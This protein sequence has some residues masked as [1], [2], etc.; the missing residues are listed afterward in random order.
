MAF[1]PPAVAYKLRGLMIISVLA[2]L[3][4]RAVRSRS[5][6]ISALVG[7][8]VVGGGAQANGSGGSSQP[9]ATVAEV[10]VAD[11]GQAEQFRAL[12]QS[13]KKMDTTE[14]T[15]IAIPST[16]PVDALQFTSNFGVRSD[17]FRGT[18]A[19]HSGVDIP[20]PIGTPIYA[21]ADGIV[22]RAERAGGYGNLIEVNHGR[23]IETR[24]GHL[25]K[26]LVEP[27]TR[28]RRGQLIGLMGST[29]RSTGSHLHY[30][31]RVEGH[32]VNPVPYLQVADMGVAI[33][34]RALKVRQVAV[35]GPVDER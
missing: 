18:A 8:A 35:G 10:G 16:Q 20:G 22:A 5:F 31:V 7:A 15:A 29:G 24:Y 21:T 12:F 23:G 26:I 9:V 17:P 30:E 34:D 27:N 3:T 32:A 19:M 13:W 28:V 2:T 14:G 33:Q 25:S 4:H 11:A 1:G 6:L